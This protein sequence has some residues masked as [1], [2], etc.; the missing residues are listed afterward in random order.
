MSVR[1]WCT[2]IAEKVYNFMHRFLIAGQE[3][4]KRSRILQVRLRVAFLSVDERWKLDT[5]TDEKDGSIVSYKIPVTLFSVELD[6]EAS[7][8]PS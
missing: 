4:P 2:P 1:S 5:I 7:G 3:V 8:I 6:R